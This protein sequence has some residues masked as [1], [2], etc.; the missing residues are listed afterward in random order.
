MNCLFKNFKE[1]SA[2]QIKTYASVVLMGVLSLQ[3]TAIIAED[4]ESPEP[5]MVAAFETSFIE[6]VPVESWML[7][8]FDLSFDEGTQS[9]SFIPAVSEAS[10]QTELVL[11]SWMTVPF[12]IMVTEEAP[13]AMPMC[14]P[15]P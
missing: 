7:S 12:E 4:R 6:E 13:M 8:P 3:T 2:K 10:F 14:C 5:G 11:E 9:E 15:A 1:L